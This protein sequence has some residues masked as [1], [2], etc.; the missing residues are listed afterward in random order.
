MSTTQQDLETSTANITG[1]LLISADSHV[2][3][4]HEFWKKG[5]PASMRD[6]TP[7]FQPRR[8]MAA[9]SQGTL[10]KPRPGGFDP[11]ERVHE[12]TEDGVSAEVLY[13]TLGL[14]LFSM[15]DAE[16]QEAAFELYNDWLMDYCSVAADRLFGIAC[17]PTYNIENAVRELERCKQ[18]GMIGG[19]VWQVPHPD[20]PFTSDHYDP[21]WEAAQA[22]D[23]PINLH[24]L[25][26]FD[27]SAVGLDRGSPIEA[28]RGSVNLKL[29]GIT[30]SLMDII[31]SGVLERFPRL[32]L[33]IVESEIGWMPFVLQQWDY[34]FKRFRTDR[35]V[36]LEALPSEYFERQ[37]H[38]TF[39]HD[40]VGGQLLSWWGAD[41]CMWSTD[42]PHPNSSW[43]H[44]RELL[45]QNLGHLPM[46]TLRKL[47][48][49]NVQRLYPT[50]SLG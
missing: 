7:E 1:G 22:L 49:G 27:Y 9:H 11:A 39:F 21:L 24:I 4:D 38:A 17:L 34:Y 2:T 37:V 25:T 5:L 41:N 50:L 20:L 16:A 35:P 29:L 46:E 31:F 40:A 32:K 6:R 8:E 13:P 42:Y 15:K 3:E 10:N 12:M 33:V 14:K 19:L 36:P 26:G 45:E 47:V 23:M 44:S 43:P 48:R 18:G 28:H 30:N